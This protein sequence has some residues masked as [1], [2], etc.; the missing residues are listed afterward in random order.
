MTEG[1]CSIL[2]SSYDFRFSPEEKMKHHPCAHLPFGYGPRN[3]IGMRLALLEVKM[4]LI[5]VLTQYKLE[6]SSETKVPLELSVGVII[7][8]KDGVHVVFKPRI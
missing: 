5:Q 6:L 2:L 7:K 1:L 3:C 4:A 8:A